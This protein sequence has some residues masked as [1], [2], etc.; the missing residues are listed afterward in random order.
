MKP[1]SQRN[2]IGFN[3]GRSYGSGGYGYSNGWDDDDDYRPRNNNRSGW[4][5]GSLGSSLGSFLQEDDDKDLFVAN[6][7]SYF[8]P[9][10]H[11]ITSKIGW[12]LATKANKDLIKEMSRFFFHRMIGD[13]NYVNSKY[14][15]LS[16]LEEKDIEHYTEKKAFYDDLWD[17]FIPGL[18]PLEKALSVFEQV[19][20]KEGNRQEYSGKSLRHAASEMKFREDVYTDPIY[21]ELIDEND[22]GKKFKAQ[23]LNK[24]SLIKELGAEFKVEKDVEIKHV[25]NSRIVA[26]KMMRDYSQVYNVELYQRLMPTFNLK[27]LTKDLI[28]NVP[29]EKTEHKQK[30]IILVDYSGSMNVEEKQQWVVALMIDRMRYAIKEEAEIFFSFF[31]E[32]TE[33]LRFTHI[34]NRE[35]AMAFWKTFSTHPT[36]GGTRLGDIVNYVGQEIRAGRLHNL[37]IDLRSEKPEILAVNDGQDNVGTDGFTYKTNAMSLTQANEQLRELC[38]KNHGK[39]VF[40]H[41]NEVHTYSKSGKSM[42]KLEG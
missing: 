4:N 8:T 5:W 14:N 40:A 17:K 30:I 28:I 29:I 9:K 31:I 16:V 6:N 27:L 26:K 3:R 1:R 20:N 11:D 21:N 19:R 37:P 7:E 36:G 38:L 15:D 13:P 39:Y 18:T 35:T 24:I 23:I 10:S 25:T 32:K 2:Q 12:D 34:K 41:G 42:M 33:H 22:F